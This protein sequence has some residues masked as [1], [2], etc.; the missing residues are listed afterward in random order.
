MQHLKQDWSKTVVE[1]SNNKPARLPV[2]DV[3]MRDVGDRDQKFRLEV[4][5][6]CFV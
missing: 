6:V 2:V 5:P 1:V 3:A 4:G